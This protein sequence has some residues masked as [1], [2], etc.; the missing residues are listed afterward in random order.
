MRLIL[1]FL[2][3]LNLSALADDAHLPPYQNRLGRE[4]PVIAV[5]GENRMTELVDYLVP[6]GILSQSGV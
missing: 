2:M 1:M 4:R 5:I 6:F 3:L